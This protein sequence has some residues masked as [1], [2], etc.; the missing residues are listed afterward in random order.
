MRGL[1][2]VFLALPALAAALPLLA[3]PS[4]QG[5]SLPYVLSQWWSQAVP[6]RVVETAPFETRRVS[7]LGKELMLLSGVRL[8]DVTDNPPVANR[9]KEQTYPKKFR[10]ESQ[11]RSAFENVSD[12]GPRTHL[13]VLMSFFT[14]YYRSLTGR[15][16]QLWLLGKVNEIAAGMR[17]NF[18]VSEFE[19]S[20]EQ[21]TVILRIQGTNSSVRGTTIVGA[22]QD[23]TGYLPFWRAP[24]ADDD[25]SGTVTLL[26]ALRALIAS[27]W[28][29][30]SNVEFHWYAAEE[31]GMLGSLAVAHNYYLTNAD[32][33][34]M[35]QQDSAYLLT[36][37]A[38]VKNG[39]T[40][41]V[42][43]VT[44]FVSPELSDVVE[45]LVD[46][47]LD[48]PAIR[49]QT[50]YAASDHSSWLRYGYPS[51]F[52][53]EA[54][55]PADSPFESC[56]LR[57]IHVRC[58]L[59]DNF[60]HGRLSRVFVRPHVALCA[61]HHVFCCRIGRLGDASTLSSS[62]H[63]PWTVP[64]LPGTGRRRR[65]CLVPICPRRGCVRSWTRTHMKRHRQR[66]SRPRQ[67]EA[68]DTPTRTTRAGARLWT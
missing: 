65:S 44:D 3:L 48:I 20:W 62:P 21:N 56:N 47:Y 50:G 61:P 8:M 63:L 38:F 58:C 18:T 33:H 10:Y 31:A 12:Q 13:Q 25:G 67:L 53:I 37:T 45:R 23:A 39:T 34:A 40:E 14:R 46:T 49:T 28:A 9:T 22:H 29:P 60:R 17:A 11:L 52:A 66:G 64:R 30:E 6:T 32:V 1:L 43:L 41:S 27:G 5:L 35:L 51:A 7:E 57:R 42:G 26:E 19:H 36:V 68:L 4:T 15:A 59:P 54:C 16:S 2:L 55:V 24:G